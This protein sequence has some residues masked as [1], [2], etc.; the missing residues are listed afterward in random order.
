[1]QRWLAPRLTRL[2]FAQMVQICHWL[3]WLIYWCVRMSRR[4]DEP[5]NDSPMALVVLDI[6]AI[7][8]LAMV[9]FVRFLMCE[10]CRPSASRPQSLPIILTV[11][12]V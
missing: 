2:C 4:G 10:L 1:M 6:C 3:P 7:G 5:A 8:L 12:P 9:N 11:A